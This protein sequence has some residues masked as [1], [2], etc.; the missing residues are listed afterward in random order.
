ML[1]LEDEIKEMKSVKFLASCESQTDP[2]PPPP[3]PIK[4]FSKMIQTEKFT[5]SKELRKELRKAAPVVTALPTGIEDPSSLEDIVKLPKNLND[6]G[7]IINGVT[8]ANTVT[9][10]RD[11]DV[12]IGEKDG[13]ERSGFGE[14]RHMNGAIYKGH[15]ENNMCHG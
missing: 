13:N 8:F 5:A 15:W 9:E 11:H 6:V 4:T 2:P 3:E 1:K 7:G 14:M 10:V 12:Y